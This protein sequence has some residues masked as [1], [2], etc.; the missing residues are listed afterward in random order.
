MSTRLGGLHEPLAAPLTDKITVIEARR[1]DPRATP[2]HTAGKIASSGFTILKG[3]V[4]LSMVS[5]AL[6]VW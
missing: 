4:G 6:A 2:L 3:G 5:G 1:C